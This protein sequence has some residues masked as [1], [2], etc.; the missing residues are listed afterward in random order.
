MVQEGLLEQVTFEWNVTDKK[1]SAME[2][3]GERAF[4][5]QRTAGAKALSGNKPE[6]ERYQG[7]WNMVNGREW[8]AM[9]SDSG[10]GLGQVRPYCPQQAARILP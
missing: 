10:H 9:R 4:Q 8:W 1:E 5:T 2:K 7:S 3:L 6:E